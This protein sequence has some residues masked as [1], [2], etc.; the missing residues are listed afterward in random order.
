MQKCMKLYHVTTH[1]IYCDLLCIYVISKLICV[2][3]TDLCD[4]IPKPNMYAKF[5]CV[6]ISNAFLSYDKM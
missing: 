4:S 3:R 2:D 5:H 6:F 1:I